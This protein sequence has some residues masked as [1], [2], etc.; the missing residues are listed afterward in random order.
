MNP[1]LISSSDLQPPLSLSLSLSVI[2]IIVTTEPQSYVV[3]ILNIISYK[4][5]YKGNTFFGYFVINVKE[6]E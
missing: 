3:L 2:T 1:S 6:T 5:A 4:F